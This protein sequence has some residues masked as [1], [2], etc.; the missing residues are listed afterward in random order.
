MS[1]RI[2]TKGEAACYFFGEDMTMENK[3]LLKQ[4]L[5]DDPKFEMVYTLDTGMSR[6]MAIGRKD[7]ARDPLLYHSYPDSDDN[8]DD[9]DNR[10]E[11]VLHSSQ[12]SKNGTQSTQNYSELNAICFNSFVGDSSF[13]CEDYG[14][15]LHI[16][17]ILWYS[18]L[19]Y[20]FAD[21]VVKKSGDLGLP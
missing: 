11:E 6:P 7:A 12:E 15:Q 21:Y 17:G 16:H 18:Y 5:D 1:T 19:F 20:S 3:R 14:M 9:I 10:V 2:T 8:S 13:S 4:Q